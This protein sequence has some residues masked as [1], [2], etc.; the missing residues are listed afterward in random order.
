MRDFLLFGAD[1]TINRSEG[2]SEEAQRAAIEEIVRILRRGTAPP[3]DVVVK[4]QA[5]PPPAG[6]GRASKPSRTCWCIGR[7][8]PTEYGGYESRAGPDHRADVVARN[9]AARG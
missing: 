9:R 1:F 6:H 7:A 4:G 3:P 2:R 5:P 8:I